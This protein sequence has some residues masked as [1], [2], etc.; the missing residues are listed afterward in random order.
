M[1]L[2]LTLYSISPLYWEAQNWTLQLQPHQCWVEGTSFNQL[3]TLPNVAQKA[4]C[5][6]CH[7][8][9]LL[10]HRWLTI[11]CTKLLLCRAVSQLVSLQCYFIPDGGFCN[12]PCCTSKFHSA[13]ISS[14]PAF[15]WMQAQPCGIWG[16]TL[17][18]F[19]PSVNLL[20]VHCLSIWAINEDDRQHLPQYQLLRYMTDNLTPAGHCVTD[21]KPLG[22]TIQPVLNLLHCPLL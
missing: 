8:T 11:K 20:G 10:A 16:T 14:L 6:L 3:P 18:C 7:G 9:A 21:H 4:V 19:V 12:F 2:H 15:L 22:L 13:Q 17:L 1:T 5:Y